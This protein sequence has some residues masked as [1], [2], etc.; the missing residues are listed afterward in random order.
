[1]C[2]ATDKTGST[3][4]QPDDEQMT[5]S[6]DNRS[7]VGLLAW[8]RNPGR[9]ADIGNVLGVEP[10]IID[11]PKL[12]SK[13]LTPLR[14]A[15]SL[16]PTIIWLLRVRPRAVIVSSPPPFAATLVALYAWISGACFVLDAHPGAFGHRD[17]LWRFFVPLQKFLAQRAKVTLVT[18]GDL[19]KRVNEWGGRAL[20][21]HEAPPSATAATM[22][23]RTAARP[24][25]V[26][27]TTFDPDEPL[28]AIVA[29]ACELNECDVAITGDDGRLS[30]V[31]KQ[32]LS[33]LAH[34][35]LTGWLSQSEYLALIGG[36]DV[37]VALTLD[38]HSVMR[39]AFEAIYLERATV[40]SDTSP[41]RDYF[42]PSVFVE[43]SASAVVTGV[44]DVIADDELWVEQMRPRRQAI[45]QRWMVQR[46]ELVSAIYGQDRA[47]DIGADDV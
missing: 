16:A 24:Q 20:I 46:A 34:V 36:A 30:P 43:N 26:F 6:P 37:V 5:V 33:S 8:T 17:R 19:R 39:S 31:L 32:R 3:S 41:L 11:F 4:R 12:A 13:R 14:Y 10:K 44:R 7:S 47:A 9:L 23:S 35:R 27:A 38:R 15:L 42:S 18:E 45:E 25:V 28:E 1:M 29:A 2:M 22:V 40:L 21:F